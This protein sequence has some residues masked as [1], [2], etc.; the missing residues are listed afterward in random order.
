MRITDQKRID[1]LLRI[2]KLGIPLAIEVWKEKRRKNIEKYNLSPKR[3]KK[4]NSPIDYDKKRQDF[5]SHSCSASY[6][7]AGICRN[8]TPRIK[9]CTECG[10][11]IKYGKRGVCKKCIL[12]YNIKH[13]APTKKTV[14]RYLMLTRDHACARCGL[15][16]WLDKPIP[17]ETHHK[18]GNPNNNED[19]NLELVCPNCHVFTDNYKTKNCGRKSKVL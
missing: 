5:C 7:N 16:E 18:D 19:S 6:N 13:K 11:E 8:G 3:C 14:K 15:T 4:C 9:N 12:V 17:L 10:S 1:H 2:S